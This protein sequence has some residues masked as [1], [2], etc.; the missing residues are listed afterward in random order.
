MLKEPRSSGQNVYCFTKWFLCLLLST[1]A[2]FF[3]LPA[4]WAD[5]HRNPKGL[6]IVGISNN[7]EYQGN[8][9]Y[10]NPKKKTVVSESIK[11]TLVLLRAV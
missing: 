3:F 5:F 11:K 7:K 9:Q 2:F 6:L 10:N 4:T 8:V 1:R